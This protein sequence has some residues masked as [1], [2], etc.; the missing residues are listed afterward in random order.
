MIRLRLETRVKPFAKLLRPREVARATKFYLTLEF[1]NLSERRFPGGMIEQ[2]RL[3]QNPPGAVKRG[4]LGEAAKIGEI[5]PSEA[6][7]SIPLSS[8]I[9][10]EGI[11]HLNVK[12]S[13]LDGAIVD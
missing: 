8:R 11:V 4:V 2:L 9:E 5:E 10:W 13:A 12:V 6:W 7:S 3:E 1:T